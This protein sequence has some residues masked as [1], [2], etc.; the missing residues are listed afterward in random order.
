MD[1]PELEVLDPLAEALLAPSGESGSL[2]EIL[3]HI[4]Q[5]RTA[6]F[7]TDEDDTSHVPD[8]PVPV[9][10]PQTFDEIGSVT[11]TDTMVTY[12]HTGSPTLRFPGSFSGTR[13]NYTFDD[14]GYWAKQDGVTLFKAYI[15]DIYIRDIGT[16]PIGIY[17][18]RI[19]GAPSG[20]NPVSGSAVWTGQV[21]AYDAHPDTLG[22]PV[23]GDARLEANLS[24]ATI[25]VDLSNFSG[26]HADM[27]W[28]GLSLIEG[29]FL[30][31]DGHN[32]IY[33]TF[34]GAEHQGI[35]GRFS[36]DRLDGI[37]GALRQ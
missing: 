36:R 33:G 2:Q 24:A 22:M 20:S 10:G 28:L 37:F 1:A 32:N 4:E 3:Q 23:T 16:I 18:F 5:I 21:R 6:L 26:G 31:R 19:Q 34:Y 7:G 30:H 14:W 29:G 35:A 27:A 11:E 25:D 9:I 12:E 8:A 13:T 15:K 17:T